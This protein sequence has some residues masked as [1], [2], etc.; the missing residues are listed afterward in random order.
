MNLNQRIEAFAQ[1]A[2]YI[3]NLNDSQRASLIS[4]A[5]NQNPWFTEQS[6]TTA[7]SGLKIFLKINNLEEWVTRYKLEVPEPRQIG[8]VM[9]GNIPL[10]GFHDLLCVLISGHKAQVKL[11]SQDRILMEYIIH[12]LVRIEPQFEGRIRAVDK[13]N[14]AEAV[15]AT[16]SNNSSRYFEYYFK[17]IPRIIRKNRTSCAVLTGHE[18]DQ[19]LAGLG[20]DIFL[21]FGLGCRNVSKIY[22]PQ[23]YNFEGLFNCLEPFHWV[24]NHHK[25]AN[26]Y[27]YRRAIY[28]VDSQAH[29]DNGFL[30][31]K[32]D[33]ELV[34]PIAVV[35][36]QEYSDQDD[37]RSKLD[38]NKDKIQC[39][40][41]KP[42]L[43]QGSVA[44]GQAQF[45]QLWDYADGIDTMRF[46]EGL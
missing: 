40:V 34:S 25:Y 28:L 44:F 17:H 27:E 35:Y 3:Q 20:N 30:L 24:I 46:L 15:I 12:Q 29:L 23:D 21:Y 6:I 33:D 39:V 36:T 11:S 10:V 19:D 5:S 2:E 45:P 43:M 38:L 13:V 8:I 41:S 16:G 18:T 37:I 9:A 31:V 7:L 4:Q 1:L 26:N 22:I 32:A 14:T 42:G